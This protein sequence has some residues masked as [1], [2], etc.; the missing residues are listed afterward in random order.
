MNL[1]L[2]IRQDIPRPRVSVPLFQEVRYKL[3]DP[4]THSKG[5]TLE[6][7]INGRA[8][9]E[10]PPPIANLLPHKDINKVVMRMGREGVAY[11]RFSSVH[12]YSLIS[13]FSC[14]CG[15]IPFI[16]NIPH[17]HFV[18]DLFVILFV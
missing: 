5:G 8:D 6:N 9:E 2:Y 3:H 17:Y 16:F 7:T 11:A 18:L 12:R 13:L 4:K 14:L 15:C 1:K 10:A